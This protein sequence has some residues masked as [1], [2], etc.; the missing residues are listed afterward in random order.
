VITLGLWAR[1]I[2]LGE[3]EVNRERVGA[4]EF[5]MLMLGWSSHR[6]GVQTRPLRRNPAPPPVQSGDFAMQ[7]LEVIRAI[8]YCLIALESV[9]VLALKLAGRH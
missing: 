4:I 1:L 9:V 8:G 7:T 2:F 6:T 5:R 3:R